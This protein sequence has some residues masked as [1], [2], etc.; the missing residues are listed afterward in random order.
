MEKKR[1][2]FDLD[3]TL[4]TGNYQLELEY[5]SS[6]YKEDGRYITE[7]IGPILDLYEE[8][9]FK[10]DRLDLCKF[11]EEQL[12]VPFSSSVLE[13]WIQIIGDEIDDSIEEGVFDT[14]EYLK[15]HD[16]SIVVLT[17]WFRETQITRLKRKNLV[18][19]F[20]DIYTGDIF[21]KPHRRAYLLAKGD[22]QA[23]ECVFI[24]DNIQKDYYGPRS[25]NMESI[26]YDKDE[27]CS[28][29][30]VKIKNMKEIIERY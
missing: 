11:M 13:G 22:Y 23:S 19:Y 3:G 29:K 5:F 20:D 2:V 17:N 27:K 26:L 24:G 7:R 4:L 30:L 15:S 9:F 1:F 10:Y 14:L 28:K 21:V 12:Q 6:I 8:Q 16:K 18:P 25:Y